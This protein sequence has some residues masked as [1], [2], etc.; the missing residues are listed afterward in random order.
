M[1]IKDRLNKAF[2]EIDSILAEAVEKGEIKYSM[3]GGVIGDVFVSNDGAIVHKIKSA[4]VLK[5]VASQRA[6]ELEREVAFHRDAL[7]EAETELERV[8]NIKI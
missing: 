4:A 3:F 1:D 7:A 6:R 8:R 2:A 5:A